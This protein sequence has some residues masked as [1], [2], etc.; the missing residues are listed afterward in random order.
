MRTPRELGSGGHCCA[1]PRLC[2]RLVQVT[3]AVMLAE[4]LVSPA[5][6]QCSTDINRDGKVDGTDLT[7]FLVEW[8]DCPPDSSPPPA[9]GPI[10]W[11]SRR[12]SQM[13]ADLAAGTDS[14][15]IVLIGD[16]NTGSALYGMWGYHSGLSQ[17]L[18]D[19]GWL[20]YG[21]PIYPAMTEWRNRAAFSLGGWNSTAYV[22]VPSGALGSGKAQGGSTAYSV[23]S[24]GTTWVRYGASQDVPPATDDWAY[25]ESGTYRNAYNGLVLPVE[26][27]INSP[28][29]TL[30]HRI[31]WGGFSVGNGSFT[32]ETLSAS[33]GMPVATGPTQPTNTGQPYSFSTYEY[34]FTPPG[35]AP[36]LAS[37]SSGAPGATGPC[38]IHSQT[39]YC[40]RKGWSVTS[41]GYLAGYDSPSIGSTISGIGSTLLK[42]HLQELRER[43]IAA[44]GSGR[45]LLMTHSGINGNETPAAWTSCHKAI[46]STYRSAWAALGY[47]AGDLAIVSF[48]GVQRDLEDSSDG[49]APGNLIPV[50]E[51]AKAMA[52]ESPDMTVID[53]KSILGYA[54]ATVGVGNGRSYYQR[55]GNLPTPG[56]DITVHLSGGLISDSTKDTSDGYTLVSHAILDALLWS[57]EC[58]SG[59]SR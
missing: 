47:P 12:A 24:P 3:L 4:A 53:V 1:A 20:C 30:W 57:A 36:L 17:S 56:E 40:K 29:L 25:I 2:R 54:R 31:R 38:A 43:Q 33:S 14:L 13:I 23:W 59:T 42:T 16:S 27:P 45:V 28:G 35:G 5:R 15:D 6:A 22:Y 46:W 37:W 58:G 10:I 48:V 52:L 7:V 32:A 50:R 11:G 8:G 39:I 41:H 55:T 49:G 34:P 18:N 44:G 21:L 19:R 26:S 9:A 51:A